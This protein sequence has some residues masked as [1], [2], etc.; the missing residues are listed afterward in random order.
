MRVISR[1]DLVAA[2]GAFMVA[3]P[4]FAQIGRLQTFEKNDLAI[5]T[6]RDV[7]RFRVEIARSPA[8]HSQGLMFR[9]HLAAD[10]GMLFLYP[11]AK[12]V[13]MWMKNTYIPLDMVFIDAGGKIV[14]FA[15]RTIPGSL[16]VISSAEPVVAVLE[17]NAGT[18]SRLEIAVGDRVHH[19]AFMAGGR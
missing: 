13:T 12:R 2:V 17:L 9:R 8:Q 10:A 18:G 16:E 7:H 4:A 14:G 11:A 3:R 19:P 1:R 15:E 6:K 5:R